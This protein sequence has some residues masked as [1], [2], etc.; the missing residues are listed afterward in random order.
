MLQTMLSNL[1]LNKSQSLHQQVQA[2]PSKTYCSYTKQSMQNQSCYAASKHC[3]N[4]LPKPVISSKPALYQ[5]PYLHQISIQELH[6]KSYETTYPK[7]SKKLICFPL[8]FQPTS[9]TNKTVSQH[10][11]GDFFW[12]EK[13]E[14]KKYNSL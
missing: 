4:L 10:T 9:S 1:Q 13:R 8:K 3:H 11:K 12:R 2:Y 14:E 7:S 6:L 5:S